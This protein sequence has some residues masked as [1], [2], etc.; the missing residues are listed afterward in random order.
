MAI[1]DNAGSIF[2]ICPDVKGIKMRASS[3]ERSRST[4]IC[5]LTLKGLDTRTEPSTENIEQRDKKM[6]VFAI[7]SDNLDTYASSVSQR[8]KEQEN[9]EAFPLLGFHIHCSLFM[10]TFDAD[11]IETVE[12]IVA[13]V[14]TGVSSFEVKT[15]GLRCTN[16]AWLFINLENSRNLQTLADLLAN[17]LSPHRS[18]AIP[19]P[20]WLPSYPE[21]LECFK[22]Y[23]SPNVFAQF[24]P[25]LTLLANSDQRK[26]QH[27]IDA[28]KDNA[29]V[30]GIQE[31]KVV[32]IG[33]GFADS[34]GQM[35]DI[36][37]K[38]YFD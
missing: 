19:V 30:S 35:K 8:L 31:G 37:A 27:F 7:L 38:F 14:A 11:K 10:T 17:G 1:T 16:N 28:N 9:L 3:R 2:N 26:I 36:S 22:K 33:L 29:S 13:S 23:G 5:A 20:S 34:V 4:L 21:K 12:D 18:A 32:G 24:E 25:H 6:N 15:S